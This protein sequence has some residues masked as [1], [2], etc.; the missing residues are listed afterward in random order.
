MGISTTRGTATFQAETYAWRSDGLLGGRTR[1]ADREAFAY[2]GLGRLESA[3]TYLDGS[4]STAPA[5]SLVFEV[6]LPSAS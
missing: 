2:D 5:T 4:M 3:K 6:R 1:G